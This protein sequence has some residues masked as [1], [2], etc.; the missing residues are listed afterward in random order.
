MPSYPPWFGQSETPGSHSGAG[1]QLAE[2]CRTA[3]PGAGHPAAGR[4]I[5]SFTGT[6]CPVPRGEDHTNPHSSD[7]GRQ[8]HS[9][10]VTDREGGHRTAEAI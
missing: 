4:W 6:H 9:P 7:G 10:R 8:Q 3:G 1:L 2:P 5:I